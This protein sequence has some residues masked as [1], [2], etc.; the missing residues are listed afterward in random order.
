MSALKKK[1]QG[2]SMIELM[3]GVLLSSF[4][5]MG[6]MQI[7]DG[8]KRTNTLQQAF[9]RVQESGR[10]ASEII[11]RD[12]RM[13]DYWGCLPDES[14]I[15]SLLDTTDTD[16]DASEMD[17]LTGGGV[18]GQTVTAAGTMVVGD[19]ISKEVKVGTDMI[20]FI[21]G[22][23]ACAGLSQVMPATAASMKTSK[24]C[25]L[26]PGDIAVL[27]N[28]TGGDMFTV[29]GMQ[30]GAGPL[31]KKTYTHN[32]GHNA[33]SE[34]HFVDNTTQVLS[35]SY[36]AEASV[37]VPVKITYFIATGSDGRDSL[38]R[39]RRGQ[40]AE[41]VSGVENMQIMYGE[42]TDDDKTIDVYAKAAS[43]TD[44][45]DVIS[46]RVAFTVASEEFVNSSEADGVLRKVFTATSTIRNR[47]L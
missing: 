3:I 10:I 39:K 25:T 18:S 32:G 40:I 33:G 15:N 6:L 46:V 37:L 23:D 41:L 35:Q 29:T 16:Y 45:E 43:V 4:L 8:N 1:Q 26:L 30:N 17:F 14:G 44:M 12:I 13:A 20:T 27:S 21:T 47:L 34:E 28:C 24:E 19:V 31:D 36:S 9:A 2:M 42:D 5:L 38:F 11:A 22:D 7:F